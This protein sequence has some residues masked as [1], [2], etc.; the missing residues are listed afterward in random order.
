MER[1]CKNCAFRPVGYC[2][3]G[4]RAVAPNSPACWA[5]KDVNEDNLGFRDVWTLPLK[6]DD[7]SYAWDQNNVMALTFE[8]G[9][10][11]EEFYAMR[12]L[13]KDVVAVI[14]GEKES[15]SKGRWTHEVCDF[16]LDGEYVFCV[17]GWGHL[18]GTGALYLTTEGAERIQDEF[19]D[20]IYN[21]LNG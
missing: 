18:T 5:F 8:D 7:Y 20:Y 4:K 14:N 1:I 12:K 9:C 10:T 15:D 2:K 13:A 6:M 11:A 21:R 3:T 19:I 17:R 16:F